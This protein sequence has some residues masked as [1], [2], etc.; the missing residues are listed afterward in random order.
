MQ[1]DFLGDAGLLVGVGAVGGLPWK[2]HRRSREMDS[3]KKSVVEIITSLGSPK[4]DLGQRFE[5]KQF[6]GR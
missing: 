5:S 1:H 2:V 6:S 4:A 3:L